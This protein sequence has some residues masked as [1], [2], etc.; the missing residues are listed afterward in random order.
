MVCRWQRRFQFTD[1]TVKFQGHILKICIMAYPELSFYDEGS[2]YLAQ[3]PMVLWLPVRFE[4]SNIAF[5]EK[6]YVSFNSKSALQRLTWTALFMT[7]II[8]IWHHDCLCIDNISA[9]WYDL[10]ILISFSFLTECVFNLSVILLN[11]SECFCSNSH[12]LYKVE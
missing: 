5:E 8:P 6:V 12:L 4:I 3:L 7:E 2:S 1:I 11:N 9:Y 10:E